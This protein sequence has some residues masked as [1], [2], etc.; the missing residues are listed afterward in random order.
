MAEVPLYDRFAAGY[1]LM[2]DWEARLESEAG[3]LRQVFERFQ[4]RSVLDAACGT[5][6]HAMEFAR[7]GLEVT[8]TDLSQAMIDR[9]RANAGSL[10]VRFLVAGMGEH[11][12]KAPGPFDAVT[13]LGNSL[14]HLLSEATLDEALEDFRA[15]LRP[16]G[17]L[18]LQNNNYDAILSQRRRFV[19]VA[20]REDCGTE[21]LFFRF[22]DL[23]PELLTF[24]VVTFAKSE[25]V[26][27]F[28]E[29]ATPQRPVLAGDLAARLVRRGFRDVA[30]FGDLRG[31]A[32]DPAA[33]TNLVV[34]ARSK[35]R[36]GRTGEVRQ[37]TG[38]EVNRA[39]T[40]C[41]GG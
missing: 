40:T 6:R 39:S 30:L 41:S 38:P 21:Y 4:V 1:D 29:D 25:G 18:L 32:F 35:R 26:W 20:S 22:F 3:F 31:A 28:T 37:S 5:G 14:P 12:Q 15:V 36:A 23:A 16:G 17:L 13:C 19:G 34:V 7:W 33:S 2:T 8:G 24:H 27:A 10:P 9:A 11:R